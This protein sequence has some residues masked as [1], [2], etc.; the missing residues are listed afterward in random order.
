[1]LILQGCS[2]APHLHGRLHPHEHDGAAIDK[3][4]NTLRSSKQN[5]TIEDEGAVG[6]FLGVKINLSD[7]GAITLTQPQLIN[8]IIDDLN[9]KDNTKLK[10]IP[11]CSSKLL[12]KDADGEYVEVNFHYCSVIGKLN[13]LEKSTCPD[14]S[15]S[16]HQCAQFQDNPKKSHLQAVRT[17]A[18]YLKGT[19]DKGIVMRLDN[20]KS[21]ECS[22]DANYASNWY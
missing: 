12:H 22:V 17:I 9:M 2:S 5:F 1:M 21:F 14:I 13:V 6:D 8:S 3:A 19:R 20:S 18:C 7:D 15:V 11:A 16:I 4:I 10:A